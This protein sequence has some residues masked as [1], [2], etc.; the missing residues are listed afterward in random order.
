LIEK[1]LAS[2]SARPLTRGWRSDVPFPERDH[3]HD[4]GLAAASLITG[5]TLAR[6]PSLRIA[7]SHGGGSLS[8]L[9]PR[10]RHGWRTLPPVRDALHGDPFETAR[11][12]YVDD[13]VYNAQ[14]IGHLIEVFGVSQVMIGSDYPFAIM[15]A[16]PAAR[17][18]SLS[19]P[20]DTMSALRAGN[21]RRW[22]ALN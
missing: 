12:F 21:A 13:L 9:L 2:G 22:L 14:A 4:G 6:W 5:G 18:H 7:L 15:D 8:A 16:D 17:V 11:R 20:A 1:S 19:L 10:L 3:R